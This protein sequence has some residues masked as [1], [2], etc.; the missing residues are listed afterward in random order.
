MF[1]TTADFLP[2]HHA[3]RQKTLQIITAA[4][5]AGHARAVEMNKQVAGNLDKIIT[6]LESGEPDDKEPVAGA[7]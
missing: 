7:C 2:Q 6:A 3:Q 4:E 5:G 1:V